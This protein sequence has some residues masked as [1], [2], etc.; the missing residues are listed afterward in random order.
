MMSVIRPA[1]GVARS[2]SPSAARRS[3]A[4]RF[5]R[6]CGSTRFCSWLT[7]ISPM[8]NSSIRSAMR[9]HLLGGGVARHLA[10]GLERNGGDG[11][12][13][14]AMGVDV[15]LRPVRE[16]RVAAS[17]IASGRRS[18]TRAA[19]NR[20]RCAPV[21]LPA[22]A[23]CPMRLISSNSR[24][25]PAAHFLGADGVDQNLDA[26]LVDIVAAAVLVIDAQ[27]ASR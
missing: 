22:P 9:V 12:A 23:A 4:D 5:L 3:R 10:D 20:R 8:P 24:V 16:I 13:G 19:R 18:R 1:L 25:D 15:G 26:R 27:H 14:R 17:G 2:K 6:T 11:I 21:P 7:R